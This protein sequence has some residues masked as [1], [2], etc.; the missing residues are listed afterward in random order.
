MN[1][2]KVDLKFKGL[3]KRVEVLGFKSAIRKMIDDTLA[4]RLVVPNFWAYSFSDNPKSTFAHL[5][6]PSPM[7]VLRVTILAAEKLPKCDVLTNS[8]PY[9]VVKLGACVLRTPT[10]DKCLDP[11][12]TAGNIKDFLVFSPSQVLQ[13]DVFDDDS[14]SRSLRVFDDDWMAGICR[15]FEELLKYSDRGRVPLS[16]DAKGPPEDAGSTGSMAAS[17]NC[18]CLHI[19]LNFF[20]LESVG[21]E[22]EEVGGPSNYVLSLQVDECIGLPETGFNAPYT[23]RLCVAGADPAVCSTRPSTERAQE[24][25]TPD[26]LNNVAKLIESGV[27][28]TLVAHVLNLNVTLVTEFCKELNDSDLLAHVSS[29]D[30]SEKSSKWLVEMQRSL[31][32]REMS[33]NPHFEEMLRTFVPTRETTALVELVGCTKEVQARF[34]VVLGLQEQVDG[35]FELLDPRNGAPLKTEGSHQSMAQ[36]Q[37]RFVMRRLARSTLEEV[38]SVGSWNAAALDDAQFQNSRSQTRMGTT[39]FSHVKDL[40]QKIGLAGTTDPEQKRK[41]K[42]CCPRLGKH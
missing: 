15:P 4:A 1:A 6:C 40:D 25:V 42:T 37:G 10:V 38:A 36:L 17:P 5:Q 9:V 39:H 11:V 24:Y 8:D 3:L 2:P 41:K 31:S 12:W 33:C 13:I 18:A 35:P 26:T 30:W 34:H 32:Q 23:L 28:P 20:K 29:D 27:S 19:E 7:G 16:L 14:I 21:L 22:T